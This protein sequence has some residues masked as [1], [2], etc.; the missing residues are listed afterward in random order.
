M[1]LKLLARKAGGKGVFSFLFQP[2][3]HLNWKA[4]Q[5][6]VYTLQHPNPDNRGI[7]RYFTIASAPFEKKVMITTRIEPKEGS[8]FKKALTGL[9][10]GDTIDGQG[11]NGSFV[12]EDPS[13]EFVFI[14]GGVGITPFR[15]ILLD[16]DHKKIPIKGQLLYA[17]RTPRPVYQ[18]EL[19]ELAAKHSKF[20]LRYIVEPSRITPKTLQAFIPDFSKPQFFL[21]G[22][23]PMMQTIERMLAE[24]LVP[25]FKIKEDYF[26]GYTDI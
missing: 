16:L 20:N 21:S 9:A 10:E 24:F 11:P 6:L 14:A 2:L 15:A 13:Q 18:E 3:K 17:N 23:P 25:S 26:T 22:P 19:E 12:I 1:T 8:S 5:Y 4:G 7:K